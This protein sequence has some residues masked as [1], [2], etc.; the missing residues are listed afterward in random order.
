MCVWLCIQ[1]FPFVRRVKKIT[2]S[3][4]I[5]C[6]NVEYKCRIFC[7]FSLYETTKFK[8]I[9]LN[10][11]EKQITL[12]EIHCYDLVCMSVCVYI[13]WVKF[14]IDSLQLLCVCSFTV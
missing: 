13:L 14:S 4:T 6:L 1:W 12:F 2:V 9:S 8:R 11:S 7:K 5:S 10:E 3:V